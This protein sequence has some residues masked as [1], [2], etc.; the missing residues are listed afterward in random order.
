MKL[1]PNKLKRILSEGK[2]AYGTCINSF[3]PSIVEIAGLCGLDF[4]RI[5]NEHAWR[6]DDVLEGLIRAAVI[7]NIS[8]IVRIDKGNLMLIKKVLEIGAGGFIIPD[9]E[10]AE[11]VKQIV[12]A[13]KFPPFGNRGYS[14][15][16]FSGRFG[17]TSH[18]E[19]IDWSNSETMVGIMIET[20]EAVKNIDE[21][22]AVNGLDF[23]LFGPADYSLSI[24]ISEPNKNHQEVQE[25]INKTAK[26][27]QKHKKYAMI[28]IGSPWKEEAGKYIKMGYNLIE[29]G[30]DY[31][32]LERAWKDA[33][34]EV[35]NI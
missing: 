24:G 35:N 5:D 22:M 6:Q 28:G 21:I 2:V 34:N 26:S 32:L 12:S 7:G 1:K 30:A 11:E 29:L 10:N 13:A 9:I 18:K 17:A 16:C 15:R 14:N 27:A 8:P 25:A 20:E 19:Y 31:P 33:L 4:C 3:N 23:I